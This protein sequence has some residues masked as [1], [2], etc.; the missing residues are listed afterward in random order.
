VVRLVH[1]HGV[2]VVVDRDVGRT[3]E[4]RLDAGRRA[5]AAGEQVDDQLADHHAADAGED[6]LLQ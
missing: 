5:A 6:E 3:A 1:L 4:R 2:R